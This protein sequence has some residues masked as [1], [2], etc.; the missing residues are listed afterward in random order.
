MAKYARVDDVSIPIFDGANYSSW[1][2]R[3]MNILEYKKCGIPATRE[4]GV[5]DN[6]S[7]YN[8]AD[9]KA[10]TILISAISD[11]QL[12][13][14]RNEKSILKMIE[15]LDKLYLTKSTPMQIICRT[16]IEEI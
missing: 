13:F 1:K 5:S 9:Q 12:E 16:K 10:K 4:R 7:D 2:F 6:T 15:V 8:E 14:I 3:L 11:K